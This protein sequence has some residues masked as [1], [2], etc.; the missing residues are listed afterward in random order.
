MVRHELCQPAAFFADQGHLAIPSTP[1]R[2][3][4]KSRFIAAAYCELSAGGT[5]MSIENPGANDEI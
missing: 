4:A 5:T 3:P 2:R 1:A